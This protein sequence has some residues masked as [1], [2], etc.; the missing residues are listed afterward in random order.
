MDASG[1]DIAMN[2]HVLVD[3][4]RVVYLAPFNDDPE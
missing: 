3:H 2:G 1:I 4:G